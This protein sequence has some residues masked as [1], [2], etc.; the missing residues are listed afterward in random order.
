MKRA[1]FAV[2]GVA[3]AAVICGCASQQVVQRELSGIPDKWRYRDKPVIMIFPI[4]LPFS[5]GFK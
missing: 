5:L 1:V 3:F 4:F 2:C